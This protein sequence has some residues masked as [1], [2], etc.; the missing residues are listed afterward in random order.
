MKVVILAAGRGERLR[1][2][3]DETPKAMV[4]IKSKP[5]LEY[6]IKNFKDAGF[7]DFIFVVGYKKEKIIEYFGDGGKF[8]VNI[9]YVDQCQPLGTGHAVLV[10]RGKTS[11]DFIVSH[12]DS[13]LGPEEIERAVKSFKKNKFDSI[14]GVKN[15]EKEEITNLGNVIIKNG[16][17]ADIIEKP[18][19]ENCVG[20][21]AFT[22]FA[23]FKRSI[24]PFLENL[25]RHFNGQDGL[26]DAIRLM[27]QKGKNV[28]VEFIEM[29]LHLTRKDDIEKISRGIV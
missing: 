13:I 21:A 2:I 27:A 11:N 23:V 4:Q 16:K 9:E 25:S 7:K 8:G 18:S 26:P 15:F 22:G 1:P 19:V 10:T 14:V 29:R 28:G 12:G 17:V 20:S 5:I 6:I 24:Y 3:T